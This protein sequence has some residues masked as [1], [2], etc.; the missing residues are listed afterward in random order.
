[1]LI[2]GGCPRCGGALH[3]E[4]DYETGV[5]VWY[6]VTCG[7]AKYDPQASVVTPVKAHSRPESLSA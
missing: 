4:Q 7:C 6:C 1:M 2:L 3:D 5:L